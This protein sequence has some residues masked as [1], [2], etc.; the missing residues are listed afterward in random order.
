M[1]APAPSPKTGA[2]AA[3]APASLGVDALHF[4]GF[5][6]LRKERRLLVGG[7]VAKIGARAF[8]LLLTLVSARDRVVGKDELLE[9]VW[10]GLVVEEN[11]LSVHVSQLRKLCGP[12]AI[13]TVPGR[14]Y[15][16]TAASIYGAAEPRHVVAQDTTELPAGSRGTPQGN[17]PA[18][19]PALIGR[20]AELRDVLQMLQAH[21][22]VTIT[23]AGGMGKT[24]LAEA[25]GQAM[26][27]QMPTWIVELA[28]VSDPRFVTNAI[29]QVLGVAIVD[30]ER[31]LDAISM[32]LHGQPTLLML[33]NCEHLMPAVTVMCDQLM[34]QLPLLRVLV[35][36]QELLRGADEAV[37]KL[38]P[39]GLPDASNLAAAME[40]GSVRL[41]RE[42]VQALSRHFEITRDNIGDAVTICQQLDGLPLA[43]E[44]A[45]GRVPMLGLSGVRARL[46]ALFR[47]LTG[48]A[49]VRLRRHQTLRAALDWSYQLL[50]PEEQVLLRRLGVFAGSFSAD[51]VRQLA[52]DLYADEWDVLDTLGSLIDKSMVQVKGTEQPRY[53]MLE[54]AR[55]YALEQL[56]NSEETHD[57]LSRHARATREV[58]ARA[59]RRRDTA[60]IWEEIPNIRAAFSWAMRSGEA[61]LA[62]GLVNDS[63][64][65][66]ALGGLVGE[67]VQRLVEVEPCVSDNLPRPLAAQYWQWLGRFG[68]DGRLPAHRCVMALQTA[69][70]MYRELCNDRHVHACLRMRA[71]ALVEQGDLAGAKEALDCARRLE[72]RNC[73]PADRMRRLRIEAKV[74]DSEGEVGPAID[75]LEEALAMARQADIHRYIVTLTQDIGQVLMNAGDW[76]GAAT[77][78]RAVL[79]DQGS[80]L[81]VV[82]AVAYAR[83]G[84][85]SA[86]LA[87]GDVPAARAA[88][89]EAVPLLRSCGILLAHAEA[90]AWLLAA[91]GHFACAATLVRT[92][93]SF[94]AYSQTARG[95]SQT[96]AWTAACALLQ[97]Q[98]HD[99]AASS[100]HIRSDFELA[101]ALSCALV[102]PPTARTRKSA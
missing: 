40:V 30:T 36:S 87:Q 32:V 33:D 67:V 95:P 90:F 42:R 62:V 51:G 82:L 68:N 9:R 17:M 4:E 35:T 55:A 20:E 10:P 100:D 38:G 6:I 8:D 21:R 24:R 57:A 102:T 70:A 47:L 34:R 91:L 84:L 13:S 61:E 101:K 99:L 72:Q 63:S 50:L 54:T 79:D 78:F 11:N 2:A 28:A 92:A 7:K 59:I 65:V 44:L 69:E 56:A 37:F 73:A 86:L 15:Q 18:H 81:S 98:G 77:R 27:E 26:A 89:L 52:S 97:A 76:S 75:R 19:L 43:I 64:V 41:L 71:E 16:F 88:A 85:A 60:A 3:T 93:D 80:D 53:Q 29:A 66:L 5:T 25:A 96:R 58:C 1:P 74:L 23:G 14:G 48:D 46:G 31:P 94:R 45:A 12:R 22:W 83:M 49:R 39:L